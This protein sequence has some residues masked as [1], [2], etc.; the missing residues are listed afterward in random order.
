MFLQHSDEQRRFQRADPSAEDPG[1]HLQQHPDGS[2]AEALPAALRIFRLRVTQ[3]HELLR[4]EQHAGLQH[5]HRGA[6]TGGVAA[7]AVAEHRRF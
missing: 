2:A 5:H 7:A 1:G 6:G 4:A 3:K